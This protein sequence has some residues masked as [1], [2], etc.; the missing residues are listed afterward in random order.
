ML[1]RQDDNEQVKF[2]HYEWILQHDS[3][4]LI[5]HAEL[6]EDIGAL[7]TGNNDMNTSSSTQCMHHPDISLQEEEWIIHCHTNFSFAGITPY[8]IIMCR[9]TRCSRG[10]TATCKNINQR[11]E[12]AAAETT[13]GSRHIFP[14][15]PRQC[16]LMSHL[17]GHIF[18]RTL[19]L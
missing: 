10:V 9:F 15:Q 12:T 6:R 13:L 2:H 4:I 17:T 16:C 5:K 8:N 18:R 7:D 3:V 19:E 14:A 11:Q 1:Q